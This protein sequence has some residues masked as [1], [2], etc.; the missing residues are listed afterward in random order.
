MKAYRISEWIE[1]YEVGYKGEAAKPGQQLRAGKL[2]FVR[3]KVH[4]HSMGAGFRRLKKI[5][6][7]EKVYEVFGYF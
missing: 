3:L 6:G 1:R 2:A 5:T 4:G 7:C